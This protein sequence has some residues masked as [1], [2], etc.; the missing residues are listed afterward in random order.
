MFELLKPSKL[1]APKF[2]LVYEKL[3]QMITN[4]DFLS[5]DKLPSELELSKELKVSRGTLRQ[6]LLL[7]QEDGFI[8]N[9]RGLGS[10]VV[11]KT[12]IGYTGLEEVS[13]IGNKFSKT[14][15]KMVLDSL[16]F[17][18][19]SKKVRENLMLDDNQLVGIFGVQFIKDETVIGDMD[20]F[21]PY[22][23]ILKHNV[24][25]SNNDSILK[26][27]IEYYESNVK[28][29]QINFRVVESRRDISKKM[30]IN[31][32]TTLVCFYEILHDEIGKSIGYSKT[33]C[34]SEF[35]EFQIQAIS[36]KKF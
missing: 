35:Y 28:T 4:G 14:A 31:E 5:G 20:L 13:I 17:Q 27:L 33:Y 12:K 11:E 19:A 9:K 6:A 21:I 15:S 36:K 22:D 2:V 34:L 23:I 10:Y 29:S 30:G 25:I 1:K 32:N 3:Y 18:V 8:I 16:T 24:S 7:L 26:F